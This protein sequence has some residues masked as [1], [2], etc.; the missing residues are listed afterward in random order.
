ML[1][2]RTRHASRRESMAILLRYVVLACFSDPASPL[3]RSFVDTN[4]GPARCEM[5]PISPFPL[6]DKVNKVLYVDLPFISV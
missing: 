4:K 6:R 5:T 2:N 1:S 3:G